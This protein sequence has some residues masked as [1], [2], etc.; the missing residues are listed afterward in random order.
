MT[1]QVPTGLNHVSEYLAN[2]VF[3][4]FS[5]VVEKLRQFLS[6]THE[7][8]LVSIYVTKELSRIH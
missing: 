3:E 1:M 7:G 2:R 5:S 6:I 4:S 8:L